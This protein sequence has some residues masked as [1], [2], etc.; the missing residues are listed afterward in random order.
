V[1][2]TKVLQCSSNQMVIDIK[3]LEDVYF[4]DAEYNKLKRE[5]WDTDNLRCSLCTMY[6]EC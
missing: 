3:E 2:A 6:F 1:E 4:Q 5:L